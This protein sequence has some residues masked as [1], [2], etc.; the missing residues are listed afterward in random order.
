MAKTQG[1]PSRFARLRERL[2]RSSRVFLLGVV[3]ACGVEVLVDWNSTLFEINVLRNRMRD[4]GLSYVAILSKACAAPLRAGDTKALATLSS[5]VFDDDEVLAVRFFDAE[6]RPVHDR[7]AEEGGARFAAARKTALL[8]YYDHQ[9]DRD[10]RGILKDPDGQAR[11]MAES[12]WRDFPQMWNDWMAKVAARF[13]VPPSKKPVGTLS[14]YQDRLRTLERSRDTAVT[15]AFATLVD[16]QQ[17]AVGAVMVVFSMDRTNDAIAL[18]YLKG[19]GMVAFFVALILVQNLT[20]R[21]DKLR[22]LEIESRAAKARA[23]LDAAAPEGAVEGAGGT[24]VGAIRRAEG[25]VDG[26]LWDAAKAGDAVLAFAIDPEGEGLDAASVA[27]AVREAFHARRGAEAETSLA[28]ELS[29]LGAVVAAIPLAERASFAL[30]QLREGRFSLVGSSSFALRVL[31]DGRAARAEERAYE[32]PACFGAMIE[33]EGA[34]ADDGAVLVTLGTPGTD[35][36]AS[37]VARGGEAL[38]E[39]VAEAAREAPVRAGADT[40][41]MV[42]RRT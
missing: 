41:V 3:V 8:A 22:L 20:G 37:R 42:G 21:R 10:V 11:R 28:E 12:R 27:L 24:V 19:A 15:Y 17:R 35:A 23:A 1:P 2:A 25:G 6:G 39:A 26:V 18:K 16:E 9:M 31:R 38:G 4:R 14:M 40:L 34:L 13:A 30:L 33:A 29:A 36:V 32:G 5:G 7:V